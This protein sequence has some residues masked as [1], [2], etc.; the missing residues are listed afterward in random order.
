MMKI[1]KTIILLPINIYR[2]T[3]SPFIPCSCRYFPS[4]SEYAKETITSHGI[5]TGGFLTIKR[6][7]RCNPFG[8]YGYD[9]VPK[10]NCCNNS[11]KDIA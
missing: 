6:L 7:V 11:F 2:I 5:F 3:I 8:G 4:C 10:R 9:P 1:V